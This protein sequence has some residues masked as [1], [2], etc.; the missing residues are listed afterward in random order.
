MLHI[1]NNHIDDGNDVTYCCSFGKREL[2]C[3]LSRNQR[4]I[5]VS[6]SISCSTWSIVLLGKLI[7]S[8]LVKRISAFYSTRSFNTACTR[9]HHLSLSWVSS[10]QSMPTYPASW[11]S[12]WI[13][14]SHLH[15]GLP[16]G[17]VPSGFPTKTLY[18]LFSP[19]NVLHAPPI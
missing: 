15:L 5:F 18:T 4:D 14:S 19:P 11:R 16:S 8:Q 1:F 2:Y 7:G 17:L 12:N 3:M 10:I 6:Q 9:A 13:L